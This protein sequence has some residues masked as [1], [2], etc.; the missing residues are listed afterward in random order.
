MQIL[1]ENKIAVTCPL[2]GEAFLADGDTYVSLDFADADWDRG[3]HHGYE[4]IGD[5]YD[6]LYLEIGDLPQ[7]CPAC[8]NNNR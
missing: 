8:A 5:L 1:L 4:T 7:K 3:E 6:A 2:H